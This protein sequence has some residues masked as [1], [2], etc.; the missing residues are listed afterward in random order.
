MTLTT[1]W[2]IYVITLITHWDIH[3]TTVTKST[4]TLTSPITYPLGQLVSWWF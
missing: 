1:H 3:V 2:D 4:V